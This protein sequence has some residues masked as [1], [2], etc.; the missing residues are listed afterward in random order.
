MK[1][2]A[3]IG[4]IIC[5]VLICTA[6][7]SVSIN[8]ELSDGLLRLHVV[9]NSSSPRDTAVKLAVR[10]MINE[11]IGNRDFGTKEEVY[12]ELEPLTE[13]INCF[14]T[15]NNI[16]YK[17]RLTK[18]KSYFPAKQ[19][20]NIKMPSGKYDCIKA[21]LGNGNGNNW[22][23]IAYPPLCFTESVT[24]NLSADG[25]KKL[26]KRL[27]DEAYKLIHADS[28]SYNIRFFTVDFINKLING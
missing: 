10:N 28:R 8:H 6:V 27:S 3:L 23:C 22:W 15:E 7:Y 19:Y 14:L 16:G 12:T 13:E 2:L 18:T 11:Y 1:R 17:C 26:K 4:I 9:A 25:E 5:D 21:T 24:G 20:D